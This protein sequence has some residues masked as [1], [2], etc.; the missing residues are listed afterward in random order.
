R[1]ASRRPIRRSGFCASARRTASSS[2]RRRAPGGGAASGNAKR[3]ARVSPY[4]RRESGS[5]GRES[6]RRAGTRAG[7]W[8]RAAPLPSTPTTATIRAAR[9]LRIAALLVRERLGRAFRGAVAAHGHGADRLHLGHEA[10]G[11]GAGC[12]LGLLLVVHRP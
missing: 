12:G 2:E 11:V 3:T 8:A 10:G 6:T 7:S 1:S 5:G 4:K 9:P